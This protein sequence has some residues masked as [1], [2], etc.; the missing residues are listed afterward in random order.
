MLS[1]TITT[2]LTAGSLATAASIAMPR[3]TT[4]PQQDAT[5]NLVIGGPTT[6]Q[7]ATFDGSSFTLGESNVTAGTAPSWLRWK[8]SINTLYAVDENGVNLN[9]FTLDEAKKVPTFVSSVTQSSGVV[10]LEFNTDQTRMVGA[11]YGNGT[12]DVWDVSAETPK[13]IK[14]LTVEG[15][16]GPDPASQTAHHPHQALLDPTGRYFLINDLGG[17]QILI[18]DSQDDKYEFADPVHLPAGSGPRHGGFIKTGNSTYYVVATELSNEVFLYELTYGDQLTFKQIS[19]QSTYGTD[20][21][22]NATSAAAGELQVASNNKDVYISNRLSGNADGD[23]LAHFQFADGALTYVAAIPTQ[24]TL[25][26]MFS[27]SLDESVVFVANQGG[28]KGLVAFKRCTTG[29]T[30]YPDALAS[31]ANA[32]LVPAGLEGTPNV[33][34]QF[35]QE[36]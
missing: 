18:L 35:V 9:I 21:P 23:S 27:L 11:A 24:G 34:P 29:G 7:L 13:L 19:K 15:T 25:P 26:R 20:A 1:K 28:D 33:G 17:D 5:K 14:T 2:L 3:E 30:L 10:F 32:D 6:I 22:A 36:I 4:T 8:S 31:I 12:V 16:L